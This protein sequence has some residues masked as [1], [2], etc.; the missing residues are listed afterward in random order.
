MHGYSTP[1]NPP[2]KTTTPTP[3][4]T[5]TIARLVFGPHS[6]AAPPPPRPEGDGVLTSAERAHK[7]VLTEVEEAASSKVGGC[8]F[9]CVLCVFCGGGGRGRAEVLWEGRNN[10][11]AV[12]IPNGPMF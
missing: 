12:P 4:N 7:D 9:L 2:T 6:S 1:T 11:A 3:I 5:Q 10:G 8:L